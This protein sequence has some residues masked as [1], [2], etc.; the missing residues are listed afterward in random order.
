ME[1]KIIKLRNTF[2]TTPLDIN[3]IEGLIP[4]HI[5]TQSELNEWEQTNIL[6]AELWLNKTMPNNEEILNIEFIK[7]LH[8]KMFSD[9]WHW[10]G[11]FRKSNKNIGIDWHLI[12]VQLKYLL[13]D[14]KFQLPHKT[15]SMDEI[16]TRFHHRLVFIHPFANGNGRLSRLITDHFLIA[17][18][19]ERFTWGQNNFNNSNDTRKTYITALRLADKQDYSLLL[20]FVKM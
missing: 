14:V 12:S 8:H 20:K 2:G 7:K 10:A 1:Q 17:Q 5:T 11:K 3:E 9:T 6:K 4:S 18:D 13:D 16:A 15:Y 19:H